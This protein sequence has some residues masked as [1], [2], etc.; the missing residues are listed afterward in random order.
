MP[1][2]ASLLMPCLTSRTCRSSYL[3]SLAQLRLLNPHISLNIARCHAWHSFSGHIWRHKEG[4]LQ[5]RN[6]I[7]KFDKRGFNYRS[8]IRWKLKCQSCVTTCGMKWWKFCGFYYDAINGFKKLC[9][10]NH[11]LY[12]CVCTSKLDAMSGFKKLASFIPAITCPTSANK[13]PQIR[14]RLLCYYSKQN[15]VVVAFG[16]KKVG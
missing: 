4:K 14:Y 1:C 10:L 6:H 5:T 9:L 2:L 16:T 12:I 15:K 13:P 3:Q 7:P 11:N 8:R